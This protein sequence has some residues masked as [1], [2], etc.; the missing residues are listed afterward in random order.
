MVQEKKERSNVYIV[1]HFLFRQEVTEGAG[2]TC[3]GGES[4]ASNPNPA[5]EVGLVGH[6]AHLIFSY[7]FLVESLTLVVFHDAIRNP[8]GI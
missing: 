3:H 2:L 7:D 1:K 6:L 4:D 5:L 8:Q